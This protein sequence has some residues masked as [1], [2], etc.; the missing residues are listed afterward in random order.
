MH[1]CIW[2]EPITH[3]YSGHCIRFSKENDMMTLN[4]L[5]WFA[6]G[7]VWGIRVFKPIW[8][9]ASAIWKNAKENTK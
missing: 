6:A 2:Y 1:Y 5:A 9:I 4:E 3:S 7:V 8:D